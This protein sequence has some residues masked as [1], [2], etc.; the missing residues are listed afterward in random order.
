MSVKGKQTGG[1]TRRAREAWLERLCPRHAHMT[2]E[3]IRQRIFVR[4][5]LRLLVA[6]K[7]E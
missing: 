7:T 6:P 3:E 2:A 4:S 1:A 5:M